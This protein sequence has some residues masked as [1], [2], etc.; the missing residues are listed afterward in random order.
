MAL[1]VSNMA[2]SMAPTESPAMVTCTCSPQSNTGLLRFYST[3]F[4][5]FFHYHVR[6]ALLTAGECPTNRHEGWG[7]KWSFTRYMTG[8]DHAVLKAEGC[9]ADSLLKEFLLPANQSKTRSVSHAIPLFSG[10]IYI[11]PP[12]PLFHLFKLQIFHCSW[13]LNYSDEFFSVSQ[14]FFSPKNKANWNIK[15]QLKRMS[16]KRPR[17]SLYRHFRIKTP[18]PRTSFSQLFAV[19]FPFRFQTMLVPQDPGKDMSWPG[20][21]PR[22]PLVEC[23][24][25]RKEPIEQFFHSVSKHLLYIRVYMSLR[26][27]ENARDI[28]IQ[29]HTF[30]YCNY[31]HVE[32]VNSLYQQI[33]E[34]NE[35]SLEEDN[36]LKIP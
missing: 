19:K 7:D 8:L 26:P 10:K 24:H 28:T 18:L 29:F 11:T 23:E 32:S 2:P 17:L 22:P 34:S 16:W 36:F 5:N 15:I 14:L 12:P 20:I 1:A 13:K 9:D 30:A 4:L 35:K 21:E 31:T 3:T 27:V 33:N 25:S 6:D